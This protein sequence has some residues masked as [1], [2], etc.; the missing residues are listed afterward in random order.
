MSYAFFTNGPYFKTIFAAIFF[1]KKTASAVT[2]APKRAAITGSRKIKRKFY[3][4]VIYH[5]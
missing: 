3:L 2:P 4:E 1:L 5:R